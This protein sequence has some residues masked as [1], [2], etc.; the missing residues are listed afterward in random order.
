MTVT[1]EVKSE[2]AARW[3][4]IAAREGRAL[5]A[6]ATEAAEAGTDA[7]E[8]DSAHPIARALA[9]REELAPLLKAQGGVTFDA[10]ADVRAMRE[11]R[12]NDVGH[13]SGRFDCGGFRAFR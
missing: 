5:E 13:G 11:E 9:L 1:I 6:V 10:A 3:Q 7:L 12:F 4:R 2:T 8:S